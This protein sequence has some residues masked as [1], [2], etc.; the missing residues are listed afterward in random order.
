MPAATRLW[1]VL[2]S[3]LCHGLILLIPI[4]LAT[5][6]PQ[7]YPPVEFVMTL[8]EKPMVSE[9]P[10]RVVEPER[11]RP[12]TKIKPRPQPK[13]IITEPVETKTFMPRPVAAARPQPAPAPAGPRVT[14][15]GSATGP[16]FLRR[17]M[18]VYPE[19]ARRRGQEGR[20]VLRLT[21]DERGNLLKVEVLE[22]GG[23]GFEEAA[24][25][26]VKRSSFRPATI[27][28]EPVASIARLPIRFVL[29]N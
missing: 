14:E 8:A 19:Q 23:F 24:V 4:S 10:P 6:A 9:P 21:I 22:A 13:P 27:R 1:G 20:V 26:A 3:A 2:I 12:K 5:K 11:V 17:V 16:A 25:E 7:S 29:R 15:F 18:P 28:G